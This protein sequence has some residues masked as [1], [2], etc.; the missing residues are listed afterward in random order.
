MLW[1]LLIFLG[2]A[3]VLWQLLKYFIRRGSRLVRDVP[4]FEVFVSE[5]PNGV[6]SSPT[7]EFEGVCNFRDFGAGFP[8]RDGRKVRP[9]MLF[10]SACFSETTPADL[11]KLH[12]MGFK[13]LWDLRVDHER[14]KEPNKFPSEGSLVQ[15]N[16]CVLEEGMTKQEIFQHIVS[17][18]SMMFFN[19]HMMRDG[20]YPYY[21]ELLRFGAP[22][23][24]AFVESLAQETRVPL[25]IHCT[26]GK[27][28]TG[29]VCALIL[30]LLGV[31]DEAI[32]YDYSLSN[33]C[34]EQLMAAISRSRSLAS[35]GI[36]D[37]D[38]RG[39]FV[40]D[41]AVMKRLLESIHGR[42]SSIDEF[43]KAEVGVSQHTIDRVRDNLL[44]G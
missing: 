42:Y 25:V 9:N 21:C 27:D 26:S 6:T 22:Q 14:K 34:S 44:E 23:M 37:S 39:G 5:R 7:Y 16:R 36:P 30:A 15:V 35:I 20:I 32:I 17:T 40:S 8:T 4:S 19:R 43:F 41:P 2:V 12:A 38:F 33:R 3:V 11:E 24:R 18:I 29:I 1:G 10:R 13:S 28:R 31:P